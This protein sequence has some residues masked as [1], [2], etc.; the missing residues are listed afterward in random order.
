MVRSGWRW[1]C[2]LSGSTKYLI[3]EWASGKVLHTVDIDRRVQ[4]FAPDLSGV[5][6]ENLPLQ[7][8]DFGD[9]NLEN[10]VLLGSKFRYARFV[11]A[12]LRGADM[13]YCDFLGCDFTGADLRGA[14]LDCSETHRARFRNTRVDSTTI[15]PDEMEWAPP[16]SATLLNRMAK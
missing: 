9:A 12:N 4:L 8:A 2:N 16:A 15:W 14:D 10:A 11:G 1:V 5:S 3:R 7:G 6:L 13:R